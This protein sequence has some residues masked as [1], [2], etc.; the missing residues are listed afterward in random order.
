MRDAWLDPADASP[1]VLAIMEAAA[2]EASPATSTADMV[3]RL[4]AWLADGRGCENI[5]VSDGIL[6]TPCVPRMFEYMDDAGISLEALVRLADH[7]GGIAHVDDADAERRGPMLVMD[8]Q[9]FGETLEIR[10]T[11]D[12]VWTGS[13]LR[14]EGVSIPDTMQAGMIGRDAATIVDHPA[15]VNL[16]VIDLEPKGAGTLMRVDAGRTCA[17]GDALAERIAEQHGMR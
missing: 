10:L 11:D 14:L 1:T 13:E 9:G 2:I 6:S 12:V 8:L 4:D 16:R 17:L 3:A 15:L 7:N 5:P